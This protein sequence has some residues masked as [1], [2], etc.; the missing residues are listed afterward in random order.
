MRHLKENQASLKITLQDELSVRIA[1]LCHDLGHG[2]FS[3]MFEEVLEH[4][5]PNTS[6]KHE[7]ASLKLFDKM[8]N[9]TENLKEDF[10]SYGLFENDIQLI[11][12]LIYADI[13]KKPGTNITY[14]DKVLLTISSF[15]FPKIIYSKNLNLIVTFA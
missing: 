12:D 10:G 15:L 8:L 2:P 4:V 7:Q 11:K 14:E 3:H 5:Y 6:W 9:E 1:G 13:F